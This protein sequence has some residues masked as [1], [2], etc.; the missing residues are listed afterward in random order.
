[1]QQRETQ[2]KDKVLGPKVQ[3][4]SRRINLLTRVSF[5]Q[6]LTPKH[7]R[8]EMLPAQRSVLSP[9]DFL[10]SARTAAT[11]RCLL[12]HQHNTR[13]SLSNTTAVQHTEYLKNSGEFFTA[14]ILSAYRS[15]FILGGDW[16]KNFSLR[17]TVTWGHGTF[18]TSSWQ[19]R[20]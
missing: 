2:K 12:C 9:I 8:W 3:I 4:V 1:M 15:R 5:Q 18:V 6:N 7:W 10:C 16:E 19:E 20:F 13:Q 14:N 11:V 17:L